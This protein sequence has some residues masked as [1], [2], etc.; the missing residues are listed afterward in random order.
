MDGEYRVT[1]TRTSNAKH[2]LYRTA[3]FENFTLINND[4]IPGSGAGESLQDHVVLGDGTFI[5]YQ[6]RAAG[7]HVWTGADLEALVDQ[8]LVVAENDC[9]VYYDE[10]NS[11]IHIYTEDADYA[12]SPCSFALSHFTTPDD[13][14]LNDTQLANAINTVAQGFK[15]GDADIIYTGGTYY[16]FVDRTVD[17]PDYRITI[18]SS[19]DLT[20]WTW[21]QGFL[22]ED[23]HGG[24][25][26]L[27]PFG[28]GWIAMV[29]YSGPDNSGVGV[30]MVTEV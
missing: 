19:T 15:T 23:L 27:S 30:W 16:M 17:H 9:G 5:A 13:D 21:V 8:G 1:V 6:S 25:I 28:A 20:N 10:S 26:V 29:E 3:D 7:T 4:I 14:L 2:E 18:Y 11:T 24:D 22:D 12:S